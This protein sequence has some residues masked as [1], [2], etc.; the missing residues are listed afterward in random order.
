MAIRRATKF[1][2]V[3]SNYDMSTVNPENIALRDDFLNYLRSIQRSDGTILGYKNDLDI[4]FVFS[5]ERLGDKRFIDVTKKDMVAFQNWLIN[6]NGNSP[7]R[8]RRMK[9]VLSSLSNY[10]TNILD[11]EPEYANFKPVVKKVESPVNQPVREK[12]VI[13]EEQVQTLLD[14]F[15]ER[16][17]YLE[18]C[19]VALAV[20]SGRRK[21]E[22]VRFK[23]DD[24]KE[25]N[26]VCDGAL[27]KTSETIRTKGF[28]RGKYIFCYTLA[29]KFRPYFDLWMKWREENGV[30]S[31]WLFPSKTNPE[32]QMKPGSVTRVMDKCGDILGI[33]VYAHAFRHAFTTNLV[34][35]GLPD[36]VIQEIVGW[37]SADMV[38]VY[39]DIA[40]E[41]QIAMWFKDGEICRPDNTL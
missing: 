24:F 27:Y 2:R 17:Q 39:T 19:V 37:S 10:I 15:V 5:K 14:T 4:F 36:G 20:S 38:K 34:R 1:N 12:T 22:L 29:K 6:E 30:E 41:E 3:T 18:A 9:S 7:A 31:E 13:T 11:D 40:A 33:P 23:V 28:G 35:S 16:G 32:E 25:A 8:V 26:L 21:S